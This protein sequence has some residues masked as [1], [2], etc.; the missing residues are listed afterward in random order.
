MKLILWFPV[1]IGLVLV[2]PTRAQDTFELQTQLVEGAEYFP[3]SDIPKRLRPK[4]LMVNFDN[5]RD[6]DMRDHGKVATVDCM[7]N[8]YGILSDCR[9]L[10]HN[11][12]QPSVVRGFAKY[13]SKKRVGKVSSSGESIVGKRTLFSMKLNYKD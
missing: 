2:T 11:L 8:E 10:T 6:I 9:P 12:H 1:F 5:G 13:L 3:A 7:V 4:A